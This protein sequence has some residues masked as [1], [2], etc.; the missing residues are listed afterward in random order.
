MFNQMSSSRLSLFS[1]VLYD[2]G[3]TVFFTGI[4]GLFFPLWVVTEM[5]GADSD[6]G[7][8]LS[9]SMFVVLLL[10]PFIGTLCDQGGN[11]KVGVTLCTLIAVIAIFLAGFETS[12]LILGLVLFGSS[13]IFMNMAEIFYNSG[14]SLISTSKNIGKI[15]GI[16]IGFGYIGA[17]VAVVI[18][19]VVVEHYGYSYGV[20]FQIIASFI[21][22]VSIPIGLYFKEGQKRYV[23]TSLI[24]AGSHTVQQLLQGIRYILTLPSLRIF[25][26]ARFW[27]MWGIGVGSSFVA[28]YGIDTLGFT[29]FQIEMILLVGVLFAMPFG[30]IW[31]ILVDRLGSKTCLQ[32]VLS[33]WA[34]VFLLAIIVPVFDLSTNIW[35]AFGIFVGCLYGGLWTADRP[36]LISLCE[37]K[38][39][40]ECFGF[41]SLVARL[42]YLVGT[43]VWAILSDNFAQGQI[44]AVV[45]LFLSVIVACACVSRIPSKTVKGSK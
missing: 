15:G 25:I 1:W 16:A 43:F 14:L 22:I 27:Y 31:G 9:G 33:G 36:L 42:A 40:G 2:V 30:L 12:I 11:I 3:N 8:T 10:A 17:L 20:S 29:T 35:W 28:L 4:V 44:I 18:G 23:R 13:F 26:F 34:I 37:E 7:F 39:L 19:V 32:L 38:F 6:Y 21:L 5:G 45:T 24:V 41:Y